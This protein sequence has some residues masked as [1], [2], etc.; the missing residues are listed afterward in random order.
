MSSDLDLTIVV[1]CHDEEGALPAVLA[2]LRAWLADHPDL[3]VEVLVVDDGSADATARRAAE[4][5]GVRVLHHPRNRGY[6]FAIKSGIHAARG[7]WILTFDGDGQHRTEDIDALLDGSDEYAMCVGHRVDSSGVPLLRRPGKWLLARL[8]NFLAGETIPDFNCGLRLI[9]RDRI[10]DLLPFCSNRFSF[11]LSSTL[12]LLGEGR[13]LRWVPVRCRE[14][15][16]GRSH[17]GPL[18]AL[19]ASVTALRVTMLSHPLRIFIPITAL[20]GILAAGF[21]AFDLVQVNVSDTS[22]ILVVATL[23]VFL[24]G[25]LAE[26]GAV[27]G[28]RGR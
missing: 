27:L 20:L 14:R 1:P 6:G 26:Q 21:V 13:F 12:A 24:T 23:L 17:V 19:D 9:R 3:R 2:E 22:V 4:S 10:L 28:R 25:L 5:Q 11:S 16:A 7:T 18:T 15:A 8:V